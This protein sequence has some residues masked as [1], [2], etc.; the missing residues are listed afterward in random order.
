MRLGEL[1]S[2]LVDTTPVEVGP[3]IT[4]GLDQIP[5]THGEQYDI[6]EG[7]LVHPMYNLKD[8]NDWTAIVVATQGAFLISNVH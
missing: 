3:D 1:A 7:R 8:I 4:A 2:G 6:Y 5:A